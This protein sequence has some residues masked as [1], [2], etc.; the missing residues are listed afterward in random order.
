MCIIVCKPAGVSLDRK[1]W[2]NCFENNDDGA[3]IMYVSDKRLVVDK[4][5]MEFK[6]LYEALKKL[7]D[8][9]IVVHFRAASPGM[10][11]SS[12]NTHPFFWKNGAQFSSDNKTDRYEWAV[13]HNGRLKWA[14]TQDK[15]DTRCFAEEFLSPYTDRDPYLFSAKLGMMMFESFI[16]DTN[17]VVV[18]R[19]DTQ[20]DETKMY[21]ANEGKGHWKDKCWFSNHSYEERSKVTYVTQSYAGYGYNSELWPANK[22]WRSLPETES[23]RKVWKEGDPHPPALHGDIDKFGWYWSY[24]EN[25]WRNTKTGSAVKELTYR[26]APV[27]SF[28]NVTPR[29]LEIYDNEID[30]EMSQSK[31]SLEG[32]VKDTKSSVDA[33]ESEGGMTPHQQKKSIEHLDKAELAILCKAAVTFFKDSGM[34]K[35]ELKQF[36][37]SEKIDYFREIILEQYGA[38]ESWLMDADNSMFDMWILSKIKEGSLNLVPMLIK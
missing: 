24:Q 7:D 9:D 13:C 25:I 26:K 16:G 12:D 5:F 20:D 19:Y 30:A 37:A 22:K 1:I 15:S 8:K 21:I 38:D 35:E 14:H 33:M 36:T 11:V 28:G 10:I 2:E 4:G 34:T 27:S 17:K 18:M 3:G 32:G 29:D 6:A 23:W 31:L